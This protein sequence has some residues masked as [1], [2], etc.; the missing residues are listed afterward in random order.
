MD[1]LSGLKENVLM[2]KLIP[3]GTGISYY[4]DIDID[5]DIEELPV[6]TNDDLVESDE[7]IDEV[8]EVPVGVVDEAEEEE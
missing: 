3:A 1:N 2:G 4:Q 6:P 8:D 5:V 7:E